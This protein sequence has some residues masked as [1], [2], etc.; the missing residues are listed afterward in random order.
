M[1]RKAI[2][3]TVLSLALVGAGYGLVQAHG[4]RYSDDRGRGWGHMGSGRHMM[5][6]DGGGYARGYGRG[7]GQGDCWNN[8]E[9]RGESANITKDGAKELVEGRVS[10]NPYLKAG[11]VIENEDGFEVQIVT[12][13]GDDRYGGILHGHGARHLIRRVA[14]RI[15]DVVGHVI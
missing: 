5:D 11:K 14:R 10:R 8:D 4:G 13:K 9:R 3:V 12:K 2:L 15:A 1:S 6:Y 7:Y